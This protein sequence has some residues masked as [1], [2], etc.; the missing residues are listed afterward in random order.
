MLTRLTPKQIKSKTDF[1]NN[2]IKAANAADGSL[3]DSNANVTKKDI[4]TLEVELY[5]FETVQLNRSLVQQEIIDI[6]NDGKLA[7]Q[8]VKDIEDHLIYI[9]DETS[10]RPYCVSVSLYPF[11]FHGTKTLGGT[12]TAPK[13][14]QSF[15]G[16]F[17][18]LVY[19]IAS[20]FAG[21][22]A[23]VEFLMYFDYFARY[24]Y[25][26]D[27]LES[28][29]KRSLIEQE[30]QGVVYALNQPASARG[31]Q[32][33]FW[34]ISIFDKYY[35]ESIFEDFIFPDGTKSNWETLEQL[36]ILFMNWFT[37]ER[38][39]EILTF[40]VVTAAMLIDKGTKKPKD[41][42]FAN[43]CTTL[44]S[45]GLS[46][47]VYMSESADSLASCCRLRNELTDNTFSYS[48]GAGGVSTG[49]LQVITLNLNRF[50]QKYNKK[51]FVIKDSEK[52]LEPVIQR[53]QK[54]L[55]AH[56]SLQQRYLKAGLLPAYDA[57][58]IHMDK[59]FLTI[60]INGAI[61][62]AEY[63]NIA[64]TPENKVYHMFI[65]R[66]LETINKLNKQ[67]F[68]EHG[69][70]FNV[71]FVPAESLGVKNAKWD[72]K[73]GLKVKRD[74]YNS[75][76][77]PVEDTDLTVLDKIQLHSKEF[78]KHLDGGAALHLNLEQKLTKENAMNLINTC[79]KHG[80]PYWTFNV[81][82]T[83]CDYCNT[84]T[85]DTLKQCPNCG[86]T[87]NLDYG[88]RVIGYLKRVSSFSKERQTEH[89]KRYYNRRNE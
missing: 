5:K 53:I 28:Q 31:N 30:L 25:G 15:C 13:N 69:T 64:I 58:Y 74:C 50:E 59:Q 77:Y 36:Q 18:N 85:P 70:R 67:A 6:Y 61:E 2:Y 76:F 16:S 46:F 79:A 37:E 17:V 14:L 51:Q 54:Y 65:D 72:K 42:S 55:L 56:K 24:T 52:Y 41:G 88:T 3:V 21:A 81:L 60:G 89:N 49:S 44:M 11:L 39:K 68:K 83:I 57:G 32:S 29:L 4:A 12:S 66:R 82:C 10:L 73:D 71:E 78:T 1:I 45:K 86:S 62:A 84:I 7:E 63:Y 8:Y 34:N 9:H 75:Y 38:K 87:D 48:L 47:F 26:E 80:V 20:G 22:V 40:P 23:T 35:F 43:T 19:Q 27:Y 33:V